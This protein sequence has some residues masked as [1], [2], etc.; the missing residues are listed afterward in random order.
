[1]GL[2]NNVII[3]EETTAAA[4]TEYLA[5]TQEEVTALGRL[6]EVDDE[7]MNFWFG[8]GGEAFADMADQALLKSM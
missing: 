4:A 8:E 6:Y 5:L 2:E 1:M 7:M 3:E